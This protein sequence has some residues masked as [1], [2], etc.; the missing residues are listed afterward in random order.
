M[1][2]RPAVRRRRPARALPRRR[3]APTPSGLRAAAPA[4]RAPARA[5][6]PPR[7]RSRRQPAPTRARNGARPRTSA[8]RQRR[9]RRARRRRRRAGHGPERGTAHRAAAAPAGR[10]PVR[11]PAPPPPARSGC[12]RDAFDQQRN[13]LLRADPAERPDRERAPPR[14][15]GSRSSRRAARPRRPRAAPPASPAF[16]RRGRTETFDQGDRSQRPFQLVEAADLGV[17][18]VGSRGR[19]AARARRARARSGR[20]SASSA[21]SRGLAEAASVNR[22]QH[23][24]VQEEEPQRD[25]EGGLLEPRLPRPDAQNHRHRLGKGKLRDMELD[26]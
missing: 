19:A 21:E 6:R 11:A 23:Q 17:Q 15:S 16:L 5:R 1:R 22:D 24:Q 18:Q 3:P 10:R 13:R 20:R 4:P 25:R 26:P 8:R 14:E 7:R 9:T 12:G 2:D